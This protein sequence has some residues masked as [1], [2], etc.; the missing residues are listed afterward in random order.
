MKVHMLIINFVLW[1]GVDPYW[2]DDD[3]CENNDHD[4]GTI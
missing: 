4:D 3:N 1:I 2:M